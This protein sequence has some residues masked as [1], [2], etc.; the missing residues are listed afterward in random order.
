MKLNIVNRLNIA[1]FFPREGG[2]LQQ[3]LVRDI[4]KKIEFTQDEIKEIGLKQSNNQLTWN[5]EKDF[6]KEVNFSESEINFLKD[7]IDL[8]DREKRITQDM[9]DLCLLIKNC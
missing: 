6:E 5:P 8:L 3:L 9:L 4:T 2:I 1:R 7:Q